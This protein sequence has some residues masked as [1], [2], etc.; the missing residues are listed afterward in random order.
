MKY[1]AIK[2]FC[3]VNGVG[4]RTA[5]FV[6]GCDLHCKGCFNQSTWGYEQGKELTDDVLEK[7]LNSIDKEYISGLSILGGEPLAERNLDGVL[8]VV[9]EFKKKFGT[10]KTLWLWTGRTL[11]DALKDDRRKH[12]LSMCDV[13]VDGKFELGLANPNLAYRGSE[14]QIIWSKNA[15]GSFSR[16]ELMDTL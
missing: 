8:H 4:V 6:S 2:Y 15:D 12:I 16:S 13:V 1:S 11:D 7:I 3:T 5:L 14:N 10:T 9:E